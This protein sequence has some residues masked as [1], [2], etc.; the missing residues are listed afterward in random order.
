MKLSRII[1]VFA[2]LLNAASVC[3]EEFLDP[4]DAFRL[5]TQVIG[6]DT[7]EVRFD[8]APKYY[9]Y[10]SRFKFATDSTA[11]GLGQPV[12]PSGKIKHDE[13][14]GDVEVY[15]GQL[16]LRLPVQKRP[17]EMQNLA[18]QITYQG[19]SEEGVCYQPQTALMK[20]NLP[21]SSAKSG[22]A[23]PADDASRISG[24]LKNASF[25]LV[26]VSFFGFG[27]LLSLTPC[28]FPMIPILSSIIVGQGENISRGRGFYLSLAYVLGMAV[29]YAAAGIA[30]GLTGTLLSSALQNAWVLGSFAVLFIVL[31]LSMF[32][33]YELQLPG[34]LQSKISEETNQ[35][36]RGSI[37]S[38][39]LMGA[40]SALICGPCVAA[41]LAGAL[42]YIG[43]TG[44]AILGGAALFTLALGMGLPLLLVGLSAG[45]LLPRAGPWMNAIKKIF[46]VVLLATAL[47]FV[48]PVVPAVAA[49]VGWALLCIIPA[50]YLH[51]LDPLP[52]NA[53]SWARLWKGVGVT[54]LVCGA[55]ILVGTLAGARD[56]LQPLAFLMIPKASVA[57]T[58]HVAFTRVRTFAELDSQISAATIEGKP[59]LLDFYADWC[60]SCKEMER[61]TF[62]DPAVQ[63][64]LK[65]FVVLQADVTANL[66]EDTALLK[67]FGLFGPPGIVF[68]NRKGTEISE[69][70]SVG[71]KD[72]ALFSSLLDRADKQL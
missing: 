65:G 61:F 4:K 18:V 56:P 6:A 28:I 24:M 58:P 49:M 54:Q 36:K 30:A 55:A 2:L 27:A 26:L 71:F 44:D 67:R 16:S 42:L 70:R 14:F 9:L 22:E 53:K 17:A 50:I 38:T 13:N 52:T 51:A 46:G 34:F 64:K 7:V 63:A 59:M 15:S 40:L 41:P 12:F 47:W 25:W 5:S 45:T 11:V 37:H 1:L 19:C 48:Q 60:V 62:S 35:L 8:I 39:V 57:E 69:L 43:Q 32:G 21:P 31:S 33:F 68:F 23:P 29:S 20:I 72:A 10:R 66:T 3:A